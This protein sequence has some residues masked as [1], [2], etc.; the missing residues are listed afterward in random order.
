MRGYK[1]LGVGRMANA[2]VAQIEKSPKNK[3]SGDGNGGL[4]SIVYTWE[5]PAG[6]G[7]LTSRKL[8][9]RLMLSDGA[10]LVTSLQSG[11]ASICSSA[12][13]FV[14]FTEASIYLISIEWFPFEQEK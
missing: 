7:L 6:F 11:A 8:W 1:T 2:I 12:H 3:Y 14:D 9:R 10:S 5:C 4:T 13:F